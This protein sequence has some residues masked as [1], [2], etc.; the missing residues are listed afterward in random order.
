MT[1]AVLQSEVVR[2]LIAGGGA[3]AI[4]WLSRIA[5]SQVMPFE[6]ALLVAYGIG[7]AVGFWLY[8]TFVFRA[9]PRASAPGQI[10]L[11]LAV[12]GAGAGV[13]L[14]VSAGVL[15]AFD[16]GLPAVPRALAEA[17]GHGFG[18]AVG[19]VSNYVGHRLLTFRAAAPQTL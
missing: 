12:N 16:A 8:R 15:A 7:M 17:L 10:A 3:A 19:A 11:F 14:A 13:V 4:N 1:S 2:F 18:I 9:A 6:A 5:L